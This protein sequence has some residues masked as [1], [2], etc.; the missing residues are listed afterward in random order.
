MPIT[1]TSD[2]RANF[3]IKRVIYAIQTQLGL[4]TE[5]C[6]QAPMPAYVEGS[7]ERVIQVIAGAARANGGGDGLQDGGGLDRQMEIRCSIFYRNTM[8]QH[9]RADMAL[10]EDAQGLMDYTDNLRRIFAMTILGNGALTE[11]MKYVSE[12][13]TSVIDEDARIY[14]RDIVFVGVYCQELPRS[15]TLVEADFAGMNT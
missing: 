14:R 8:D 4:S 12:T 6:Y 10:Q 7:P 1:P 5:Q 2:A 15:A 11:P 13:S 9:Q 3:I